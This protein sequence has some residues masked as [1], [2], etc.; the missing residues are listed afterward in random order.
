M[1][2]RHALL[3]T[4]VPLLAL[5]GPKAPKKK[6]A[7][8]PSPAAEAEIKQALDSTQAKVGGCVV[9]GIEPGLATWTQVVRLKVVVNGVG[10][11]T[12]EAALEP[13]NANAAKTKACIEDALRAASFPATHAPMVTVER[14]WTFR[15]Q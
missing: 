1:R 2:A 6:K 14:E 15:M 5:A 4:L 8:P 3:L 7:P 11:V 9:N 10:Q 12:L 13:A